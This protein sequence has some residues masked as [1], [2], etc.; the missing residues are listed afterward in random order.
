MVAERIAR[1]NN[2]NGRPSNAVLNERLARAREVN[3][4]IRTENRALLE[5]LARIGSEIVA[6][7]RRV[8]LAITADRP[9]VAMHVAGRLDDLGQACVRRGGAA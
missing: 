8:E 3:G 2:P 7:G 1:T 9:D 6:L 5:E 4:L